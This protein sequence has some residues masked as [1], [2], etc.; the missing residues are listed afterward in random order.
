MFHVKHS[1][2]ISSFT[3]KIVA[4]VSMTC[5][6]VANVFAGTLPG[7][8]DIML[9]SL[10]G[11]TFP[12]MS[13]MLTEGFVHTSNIKKY[14][15]RLFAFALVSQVPYSLL[16]GATPN[17]LFTLLVG[18]GVLFANAKMK[19]Q[20]GFIAVFLIACIGTIPFDWGCIGIVM[21]YLFGVLR[22]RKRK[23][24]VV[25]ALI[26]AFL[27]V[28]PT[29]ISE[30]LTTNGIEAIGKAGNAGNVV[31]I[32][33]AGF[34][35]SLGGAISWGENAMGVPLVAQ[36][37]GV[38]GTNIQNTIYQA[39]QLMANIGEVGYS[40]IGFG[41]AAALLCNYRGRRGRSLKWLFYG[42]YPAHL[43]IIWAV[44]QMLGL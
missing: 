38:D 16:W 27:A 6:H 22:G 3:L 35:E 20:A 11:A 43:A 21:I 34:A 14:A 24:R 1:S 29:A 2:D 9:Y 12:I 19:S 13:F 41:L 18:L 33:S 44:A 31:G 39:G 40:T 42:Y 4:I 26:V 25:A 7:G 32:G 37:S 36:S 5:N 23:I 28:F 15:G 30:L 8:L 17:V 10:G